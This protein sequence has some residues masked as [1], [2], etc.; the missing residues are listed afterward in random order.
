MNDPLPDID[1][2]VTLR[3]YTPQE[4]SKMERFATAVDCA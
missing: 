2:M 3:C 1:P 4:T